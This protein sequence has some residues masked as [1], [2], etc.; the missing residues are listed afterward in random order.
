M[1]DLEVIDRLNARAC[2]AEIPK[3]RA[4]GKFVVAIY[5][6]L[7]YY[8]HEAFANAIDAGLY[9]DSRALENNPG[10]RS[11]LLEPTTA[12]ATPED[13]APATPKHPA[14]TE[15]AHA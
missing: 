14:K 1:Q 9:I 13:I 10:E 11:Q 15:K 4:A 5:S 8:S 2:A 12:A 7:N 3:L 6:G